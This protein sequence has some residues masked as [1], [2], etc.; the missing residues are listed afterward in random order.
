LSRRLT[1]M[2]MKAFYS[3]SSRS[4]SESARFFDGGRLLAH[5]HVKNAKAE[6]IPA[7]TKMNAPD[8][9]RKGNVSRSAGASKIMAAMIAVRLPKPNVATPETTEEMRR[10]VLAGSAP[11]RTLALSSSR[12]GKETAVE[13]SDEDVSGVKVECPFASKRETLQRRR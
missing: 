10:P 4:L 1:L 5:L 3:S 6:V 8:P 7:K 11:S 9:N 12:A 2:T 13:V